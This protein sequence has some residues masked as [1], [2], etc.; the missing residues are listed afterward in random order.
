MFTKSTQTLNEMRLGGG[1]GRHS[2]GD[3]PIKG[4]QALLGIEGSL[5]NAWLGK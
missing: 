2:P 1:I 3:A 4:H 5:L